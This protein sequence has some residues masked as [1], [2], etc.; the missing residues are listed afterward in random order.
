M[1]INLDF[2]NCLIRSMNWIIVAAKYFFNL[3]M[4]KNFIIYWCFIFDYII[5]EK[6][7]SFVKS[8][9]LML[10]NYCLICFKFILNLYFFVSD[11]QLLQI[12]KNLFLNFIFDFIII[13]GIVDFG[14][15][16]YYLYL[17]IEIFF[18]WYFA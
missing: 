12:F 1:E 7:D 11:K 16:R 2:F 5:M 10:L 13:I 9:L 18:G 4:F 17:K 14:K 15:N 6:T 3:R 8:A